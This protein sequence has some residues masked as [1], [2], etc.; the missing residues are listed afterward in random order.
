MLPIAV[1]KE[2]EVMT[3]LALKLLVQMNLM[4][5]T[6]CQQEVEELQGTGGLLHTLVDKSFFII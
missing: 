4:K 2:I 3:C 6:L 1:M 5:A